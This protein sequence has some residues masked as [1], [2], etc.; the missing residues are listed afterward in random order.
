MK[1]DGIGDG[2]RKLNPILFG[3]SPKPAHPGLA[4]VTNERELHSKIFDECRRRGWIAFHGSM[5]E[6]THRTE[7]EP[8]FI[9]LANRG[10]TFFI[11]CK[12]RTGK[13]SPAQNALWHQSRHLGHS[14]AIVRSFED[15]LA[16]VDG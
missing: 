11:E 7:G 5:A 13:L 2:V 16:I 8:D 4:T 15:F 6:R 12:T 10:R 3:G 14:I 1:L 9:I